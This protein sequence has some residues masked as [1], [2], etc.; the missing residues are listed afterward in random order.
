M[1]KFHCKLLKKDNKNLNKFLM[2][3]IVTKF[4]TIPSDRN[5]LSQN[6]LKYTFIHNFCQKFSKHIV[7]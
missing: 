5:V 3:F 6:V 2:E 4:N 7:L 1:R